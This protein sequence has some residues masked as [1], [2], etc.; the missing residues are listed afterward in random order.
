MQNK[1]Y[2]IIEEVPVEKA[3]EIIEIE[4]FNP[5][6]DSRGRFAASGG[7]KFYA[8]PGKSRAH[9][10]AIAREKRR[11]NSRNAMERIGGQGAKSV[12]AALKE[13][14]KWDEETQQKVA[15]R[16]NNS[17][18]MRFDDYTDK[19][20]NERYSFRLYGYDNEGSSVTSHAKKEWYS[21]DTAVAVAALATIQRENR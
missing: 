10:L 3:V 5:Y 4:K 7:G 6:H 12:T 16:I 1:D 19:D 15:N 17:K 14:A 2:I 9:D 13:G 20:G 11:E 21:Y 18:I 8:T